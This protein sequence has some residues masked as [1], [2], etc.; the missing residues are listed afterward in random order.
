MKD[1]KGALFPYIT[2]SLTEVRGSMKL[3]AAQ[4][5]QILLRWKCLNFFQIESFN[6]YKL[7]IKG[8]Q[9]DVG[10]LCWI[11]GLGVL[12]KIFLNYQRGGAGQA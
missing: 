8:L 11:K 7:Y 1:D 9:F 2:L 10:L 4:M 3:G 6:S 5:K 12:P